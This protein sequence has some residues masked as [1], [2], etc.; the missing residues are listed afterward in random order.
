MKFLEIKNIIIDIHGMNGS[1]ARQEELAETVI[2]LVNRDYRIH[3]ISTDADDDLAAED[4]QHANLKYIADEMPPGQETLDKYPGITGHTALWVTD[5]KGLQRW[6]ATM[7]TPH[8]SI[9]AE[10][11]GPHCLAQLGRL[12]DLTGVLDP[13]RHLM[14][15]IA[16]TVASCRASKHGSPLVIGIGGP[17]G[18]RYQQFSLDLRNALSAADFPLVELFD[19]N[20]VVKTTAQM[21]EDDGETNDWKLKGADW[22][23]T[24]L[25][26]ALRNREPF[27]Q[28][29][30]PEA[31]HAD[32]GPYFPL[33]LSEE[34]I[35]ICFGEMPFR[36]PFTDVIDLDI[37]LE[38][39]PQ[40]NTRRLYE[41]PAG[42]TFDPK[43]IEQFL[44]REGKVYQQYLET[45]D[46]LRRA[47][48][49]VNANSEN[50]FYLSDP[51]SG[52]ARPAV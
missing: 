31:L 4:F 14:D 26:P 8:V 2:A 20:A 6:L 42:E 13:T 48:I 11:N 41:I 30:C 43:F 18:S 36:P 51:D 46:V 22:F 16:Q 32:Y 7:E 23:H 44:L 19:M 40:E 28:E 10:A 24:V 25:I 45:H 39:S 21:L 17:P 37:L 52:P 12:S 27:Y 47:A 3:I 33:F 1:H 29:D 9:L 5:D 38:L 35:L 15:D 50:A 49:R 34:S